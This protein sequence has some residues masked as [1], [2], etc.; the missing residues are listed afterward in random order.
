MGSARPLQR[1]RQPVA[2]GGLQHARAHPLQR[3][4]HAPHRPLAQRS[5][6]V[7]RRGDRRAGDRADRQPAAGA[8]IAEI[9]RA[10]RLRKAGDA[11]AVNSP[12][13]LRR[14]LQAGAERAHGLGGVQHV[15]AFQQAGD[16]AFADRQRPEN[17][18]PVRD[19]FVPR[20]PD[21]ALQ[22]AAAA[23][24]QRC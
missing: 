4:E 12:H 14:P 11:D 8:G 10:G 23:G 15:L 17:Q 3:V 16:R 24:R 21:T 2:L 9:E 7:E 18:R 20:H 1:E 5:I 19:R 6:A 22:G 13:A